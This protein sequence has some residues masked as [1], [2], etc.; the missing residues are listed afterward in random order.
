MVTGGSGI[1]GA[2]IARQMASDGYDVALCYFMAGERAEAVA[3]DI[4]ARDRNALTFRAHLGGEGVA[5]DLA[6]RVREATGG[7]EVLVHAAASGVMRPA[8]GLSEHHLDWAW[9]VNARSLHPLM[10]GL[11]PRAAV[12]LSSL[13]AQR[14]VAHYLGVGVSK[15]ALEALVR[16]L[17]VELAPGTRLN[18]LRVGLVP[19]PASRRLPGYED[20]VAE[21]VGRTPLGRLPS[22]ADVA[23]A[24]AWLVSPASAMV[25]GTTVVLDGG[26]SL[27]L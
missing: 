23:K 11:R 15:A 3:Q 24:V 2:E 12:V 8:R 20:L 26:Q 21:T 18:A 17:A 1:I 27:L 25:T 14:S 7:V 22:P 19:S 4:R 16:Y 6:R 5:G 9:A 13:G 10:L